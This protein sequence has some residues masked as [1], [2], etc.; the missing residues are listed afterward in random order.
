MKDLKLILLFVLISFKGFA[1]LCTG[2]LGDPVVNITFGNQN[3]PLGP[4]KIGVT[5]LNYVAKDCPTDGEYTIT[6]V[7]NNCFSSTW[8]SILSDHTGE[9]GGRF[10]LINASVT[11]DDFYVDTVKGLCGNTTYEFGAWVAN[12]LKNS[13][14]GGN[15]NKPNL[16]FKIETITGTVLGSYSTGDIQHQSSIVWKQYG[17]FFKPN[18]N[19]NTII[20]RITNNAAGGCGNDLAID[21]ITFRPCGPSIVGSIVGSNSTS[22]NV[23]F[24]QQQTYTLTTNIGSG[25]INPVYQWQSTTDTGRSWTNV[26]NSV[27]PTLIR[28]PTGIG[29]YQYRLLVGEQFNSNNSQCKTASNVFTINIIGVQPRTST[30]DLIACD[31]SPIQLTATLGPGV[32]YTWDGPN[33]YTANIHNPIIPKA[34]IS[35]TG[36][37]TV[38]M[39]TAT[40][41]GV[42]E[43]IRLSIVPGVTAQIDASKTELCLNES[44]ILTASGGINY[45]WSPAIGLTSTNTAIT[46]AS[47]TDTTTYKVMVGSANGCTDSSSITIVRVKNP[48]VDAGIDKDIFGGNSANL[49]ATIIG[50]YSSFLWTP[51]ISMSNSNSLT[52]TV[53][54]NLSTRYYLNVNALQNCATISDSVM[55][56][57]FSKIEPPNAFSPNGD[58]QNDYWNVQGLNAYPNASLIIF[59]R[60]AQIVFQAKPYSNGWDG[61]YKGSVLPIGTYYY[62]IDRG[63]GFAPL[64]GSILLIR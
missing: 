64:S 4:L 40:G 34:T 48:E 63:P 56:N 35:Q 51:Q 15:G 6:D 29:F 20:L 43:K 58:G 28:F 53:N 22:M 60:N 39:R 1:Q 13:S 17:F 24:E 46:N 30:M 23:C 27:T 49:T 44:A 36:L 37:Y 8:H 5:N 12:V 21:D 16:T 47:P 19:T 38:Q 31:G 11:P 18:A 2:S 54:P 3:T 7:S 42:S 55:V 59:N 50:A 62:I 26:F 41:C 9:D 61:T 14:C 10:M 25:F 32:F 57:V 45:Q 52:P 33:G